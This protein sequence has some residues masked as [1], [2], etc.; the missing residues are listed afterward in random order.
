MVGR[1]YIFH[2]E[3]RGERLQVCWR[4]VSHQEL[5]S[6]ALLFAHLPE[7]PGNF[8]A[9]GT[10]PFQRSFDCAGHVALFNRSVEQRNVASA[11]EGALKRAGTNRTEI[12]RALR[13]VSKKQSQGMQFLVTN[14]PPADLQ[15]LSSAFL[16][17]NVA[18]AYH[19][20]EKAP[21]RESIPN[22]VFLNE[23]LPYA[24]M[25]ETREPWR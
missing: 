22:E 3:R 23:I 19:A 24:S 16:V 17:E 20:F 2:E 8:R 1:S 6:L 12:A 18:A 7:C 15:T 13:Q 14:M 21:W 10:C 4:H 9:I 11:I 25:T 5:H